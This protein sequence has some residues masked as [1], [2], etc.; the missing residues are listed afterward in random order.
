MMRDTERQMAEI[1][2]RSQKVHVRRSLKKRLL[3]SAG[4]SMLCLVL[5]VCV[6]LGLPMLQE[7]T[8]SA[9]S[10]RFGSLI[11]SNSALGYALIG[12]L[13]FA[14]GTGLTQFCLTLRRWKERE[15]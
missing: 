5:L 7:E 6:G 15:R 8:V 2:S 4:S 14:L 13:C 3:F 9:E 12:V 11:L 10:D 1:L